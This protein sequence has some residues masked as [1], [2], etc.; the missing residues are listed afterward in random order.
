MRRTPVFV[1][2]AFLAG[3]AIGFFL[4]STYTDMLQRRT[5]AATWLPSKNSTKQTLTPP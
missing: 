1:T 3:L 2:V 4:R 5:H